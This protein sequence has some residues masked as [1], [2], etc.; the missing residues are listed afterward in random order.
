LGAHV[1]AVLSEAYAKSLDPCEVSAHGRVT[2]TDEVGIDVETSVRDYT[3][4]LALLAMEVEV[5]AV[6]ARESRVAAGKSGVEITHLKKRGYI[7]L[8][9]MHSII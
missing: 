9:T 7:R 3:E 1:E 4:I 6:G 2:L 8:V 5:I